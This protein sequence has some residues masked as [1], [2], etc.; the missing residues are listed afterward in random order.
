M[1]FK[2]LEKRKVRCRLQSLGKQVKAA[3]DK[4][5]ANITRYLLHQIVQFCSQLNAEQAVGETSE[6]AT[7]AHDKMVT[8]KAIDN[9][10]AQLSVLDIEAHVNA[11]HS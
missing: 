11:E 6:G 10:K 9:R 7:A 2:E 5:L 1:K 8:R 3:R 4:E